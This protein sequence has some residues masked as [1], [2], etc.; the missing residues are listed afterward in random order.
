MADQQIDFV[1]RPGARFGFYDRLKAEFPSQILVDVAEICNLACIHCPHPE[2]KKSEHY[3]GSYLAPALNA[4]L[5]D[6]VRKHGQGFTQYIRYAS[7]GEPLLHP[8]IYEMMEYAKKHSGVLVTLTTNGVPLNNKRIERLLSTGVDVIDISIDAFSSETYA[9][10]RVNGDLSITRANTLRLLE[11]SKQTS[12]KTKVVVS[13]V[14]MPQNF[15][16]TA[17]FESFWK[18]HGADYVVIRR[19]HSC[20]GS[21][22]GLADIKR[23]EN[24]QVTRRPCLYPWE[25]IVL[26]P[27][28]DLAWCPS[29]WVHGSFIADYRSTT[30]Y[31]TWQSEFYQKLRGAHLSND[32]SNHKFC[33]QC[34]D[35]R[36]TRWPDEGRSYA[37]MMEEFKDTE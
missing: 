13:Y 6:E 25:R 21:N 15:H 24:E 7:A 22:I 32:F 30:I 20:S 8:D 9:R 3:S 37:D 36:A 31:E 14:E 4:K 16:E 18:D 28:G 2:F 23:K 12:F 1:P 5:V 35:W 34:P 11:R 17:D 33:G 10:I 29:D 26:N 27:K 19:L